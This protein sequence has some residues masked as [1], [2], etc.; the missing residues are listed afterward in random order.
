MIGLLFSRLKA[1]RSRILSLPIAFI[2][3]TMVSSGARKKEAWEIAPLEDGK[4][5]IVHLEET[6]GLNVDRLRFKSRELNEP[7]FCL[8]LRPKTAE[9]PKRVLIINH[10]WF[11]RPEYLLTH[12]HL[13][14]VYARLLREGS[15]KP[16]L[17]VLPDIRF[18]DYFR[19]NS[20]S[21]PFAQYLPL[22]AEEVFDSVSRQYDVPSGRDNWSIS[23]FSF[24]GYVSLDIGRRYPGRFGSIGV[25]SSFYD[26]DWLFWPTQPPVENNLDSK[27]RGKQTVVAPGPV[28]SIFLACG[29]KDR[30][31]NVMTDLHGKFQESGIPHAW[32][33]ARGGHTWKYWNS[34][35][36]EMLTFHLGN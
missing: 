15:I 13:D 1:L 2:V 16:A 11:D 3:A 31:F 17:L 25:I 24:G 9:V 26:R 19:K 35:L 27:G 28:P 22:V 5:E 34:V 21:F 14:E 10:G 36:T 30:F 6:S 18:G 8:V 4:L 23:G 33:T 32:S 7:R 20:S 29:T 12:L